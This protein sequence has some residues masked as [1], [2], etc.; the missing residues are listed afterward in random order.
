MNNIIVKTTLLTTEEFKNQY[1]SLEKYA[2]RLLVL[3]I[4]ASIIL[5]GTN[6]IYKKYKNPLTMFINKLQTVQTTIALAVFS[7]YSVQA[8]AYPLNHEVGKTKVQTEANLSEIKEHIKI[9]EGKLT[10]ESLPENYNY[11]NTDLNK[12]KTQDFEI[13]ESSKEPN[14]KL[15]DSKNNKYEITQ[16]QLEELEK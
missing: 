16:K 8:L 13:Y 7:W 12:N 4:I 14:V 10:I 15:I 6:Y 9:S 5:Y 11:K 1:E 2:L 3:L